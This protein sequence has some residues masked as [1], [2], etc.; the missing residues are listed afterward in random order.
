MASVEQ[1][2]RAGSGGPRFAGQVALVTGAGRG[3]GQETAFRFAA[4]GAKVAAVD[5][6]QATAE[7]T[8][9]AIRADGGEA[10]GLAGDVLSSASVTAFVAEAVRL[11]GP[12]SV[13]VNNAGGGAGFT[14]D[15][16]E[17]EWD[18]QLDL[19][20]KSAYLV[21][22]AVWPVMRE[23]G[24]GVILNASSVAGR[25]AMPGLTAYSVAKAGIV[26]LTKSLALEGAPYGIRVNCVV[27][28]NVLTPALRAF[29][30]S[31]DDPD[32]AYAA[33]AK[34]AAVG[35]LGEGQDIADAYLYLASPEASWVTGTDL[36]IDGG[37]TLG[38]HG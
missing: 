34:A 19:N 32:A 25:W 18:R 6:D 7:E 24:G 31:Q 2:G 20:L 1:T 38:V 4:A 8:A 12:V 29:F 5:L 17:Q 13:L 22:K 37:F 3:I 36:L 16:P 21:A 23:N 10:V 30:D 28:G 33:A 15:S 11:L 35:R 9:G 14:M 26:M 27:P